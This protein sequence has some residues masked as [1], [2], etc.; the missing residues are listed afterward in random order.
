MSRASTVIAVLVVLSLVDLAGA[1]V[2][3]IG[4]TLGAQVFSGVLGVV[5]L[6][7]AWAYSREKTWSRR[8]I[9]VTRVLEILNAIMAFGAGISAG[10]LAVAA[11]QVALSVG[12]IVTVRQ[13]R[14][15]IVTA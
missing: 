14:A 6:Y 7:G 15:A 2:A 10:Y 3:P 9:I 1:V 4:A 12:V 13:R 11:A 5:T 8:L